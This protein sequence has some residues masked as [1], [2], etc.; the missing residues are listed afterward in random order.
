MRGLPAAHA[1]EA[2]LQKLQAEI[3]QREE[4]L[5]GLSREERSITRALGEL[6]EALGRLDAQGHA[7]DVRAQAAEKRAD[8][9]ELEAARLTRDLEGTEERLRTRLKALSLLG[10]SADLQLILG[11]RSLKDL[12]WR[13]AVL[14]RLAHADTELAA[15]VARRRAELLTERERMETSRAELARAR[16]D[17]AAARAAAAEARAS[18]AAA[19]NEVAT[20]KGAEQRRLEE[21][22]ASRR[23]L[24]QLVEDLPPPA[25]ASGF[26]ALRGH[27]PWPT[28]GPVD[29]AFG[30]RV[31]EAGGAEVMHSGV[32][33]VAPLGQQVSAVAP[34]RVVH[35]GWL[36][37]FGQ[38]LIVDHGDGYHSLMAH[39]S[40]INVK[41]G[42]TV[43]A[44]D[45]VAYVGDSESLAGPRLYFELRARGRPVDPQKWLTR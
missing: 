23:R 35:A 20:Q 43:V 19:I 36:R 24:Q 4:A 11:S 29:V 15:G 9:A 7:L 34:G 21:L 40:R 41:A 16:L 38:L 32:S 12:M 39:L 13:R 44:G 28:Q 33:L 27:L 8:A 2:D 42:D 37:G 14:R 26:A 31:A 1:Q 5:R 18:R 22:S 17:L 10:P 30:P 45:V 6:D 25:D 3:A